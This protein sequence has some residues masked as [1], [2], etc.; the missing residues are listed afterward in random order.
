MTASSGAASRVDS[1]P[2][3]PRAR[4]RV[5]AATAVLMALSLLATG[6]GLVGSGD[7]DNEPDCDSQGWCQPREDGAYPQRIS[8][9]Y[10]NVSQV[11]SR[12]VRGDVE[13]DQLPGWADRTYRNGAP[14]VI[15]M[16]TIPPN[17]IDRRNDDLS[18]HF[19]RLGNPIDLEEADTCRDEVGPL[20]IEAT[21][22]KRT[23]R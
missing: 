16:A 2:L 22:G 3:T 11:R 20:D 5:R 13:L 18:A 14:I 12:V 21:D 15:D 4:L 9:L 23:A 8:S 10:C 1:A 19:R 6:C 17:Q 7:G